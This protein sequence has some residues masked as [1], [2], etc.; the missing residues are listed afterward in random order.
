MSDFK[1]WGYGH[2]KELNIL[3]SDFQKDLTTEQIYSIRS[4]A[5]NEYLASCHLFYLKKESR[6]KELMLLFWSIFWGFSQNDT[7]HHTTFFLFHGKT[8]IC[9]YATFFSK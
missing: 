6:I 8:H 1:I 3:S 5:K 7:V 4:I 2:V 9:K